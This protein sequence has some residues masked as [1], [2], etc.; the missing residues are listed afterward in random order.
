MTL[1][2]DNPIDCESCGRLMK[3]NVTPD[4]PLMRRHSPFQTYCIECCPSDITVAAYMDLSRHMRGLAPKY[5]ARTVT[6][7]I[8]SKNQGE[9]QA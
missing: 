2:D 1:P 7:I 3:H 9:E 5:I 4:V 6:R 8:R